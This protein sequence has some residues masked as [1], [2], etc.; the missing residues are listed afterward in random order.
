MLNIGYSTIAAAVL[1]V[2]DTLFIY[3]EILDG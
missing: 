3:I 2:V 1:A